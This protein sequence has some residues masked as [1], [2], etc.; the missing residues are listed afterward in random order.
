MATTHLAVTATAAGTQRTRARRAAPPLVRPLRTIIALSGAA[1]LGMVTAS[2]MGLLVDGLYGQPASTA[3]MLR[4]YDVVTLFAAAPLLV[5][6][7]VGVLRGSRKALLVW[8]GVLAYN[9]YNY[10]IY[11]FATEFNDA[12]LLHVVTFTCSAVALGLGLA[13]MDVERMRSS[14]RPRTPVRVVS[15]VLGLLGVGLGAMWVVVSLQNAFTGDIPVGSSLVETPRLVHLGIVLDLTLLVPAYVVAA[16]L[17][18]R[19]E[20]WGYVMAGVLLVSGLLHQ[21]GYLVAMPMQVSA[22]IPGAT[23]FDPLEPVIAALFLVGAVL[24]VGDLR[25]SRK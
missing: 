15:V 3:S 20:A 19:R 13:T 23:S 25:T 2:L 18:W 24:M 4:G 12:F 17:L 11:L 5:V 8:L 9:V 1:L 14:Y 16:V 7:A 21:I 10:A 6:S 22:D